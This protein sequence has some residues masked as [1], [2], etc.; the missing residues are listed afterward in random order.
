VAL[1]GL[2]SPLV[3]ATLGAIVL[4]ETFGAVQLAG[5]ALALAAIVGGQLAPHQLPSVEGRTS[6]LHVDQGR[7]PARMGGCTTS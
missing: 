6:R 7:S 2:L 4:G 1:L 3:A 5:F